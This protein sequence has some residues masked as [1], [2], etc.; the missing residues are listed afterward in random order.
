MAEHSRQGPP[1]GGGYGRWVFW[2][3]VAIALFFLVTEHRAHVFQYLPFLLLAACPLLHLLHGHG[4]H[5]GHNSK[6]DPAGKGGDGS[7]SRPPD[8]HGSHR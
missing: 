5:G 6:A 3:F 7:K 2:G 1:S 8:A 4:G